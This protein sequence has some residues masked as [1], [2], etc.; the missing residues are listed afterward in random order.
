M[1]LYVYVECLWLQVVERWTVYTGLDLSRAQ[2]MQVACQLCELSTSAVLLP[3]TLR[4]NQ[5]LLSLRKLLTDSLVLY[6]KG[7]VKT[8]RLIYE[9]GRRQ[10]VSNVGRRYS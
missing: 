10:N 8:C 6:K 4:F 2:M 1:C 9:A 3:L 5:V 7:L